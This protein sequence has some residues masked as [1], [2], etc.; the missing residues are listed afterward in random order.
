[1][2]QARSCFTL[3]PDAE[4]T[5]EVNP[6]TVTLDQLYFLRQIG[7]NRINIG[8]QSFSGDMLEFLGRIHTAD[9]AI[10]ALEHARKAGFDNM[11]L[12]LIFGI[13]GQDGASW[14]G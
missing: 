5:M 13:P 10:Q 14:R 6:G 9:E 11:G 2:Q 8:V 1:M 4:I 12:D 7:I 3:A